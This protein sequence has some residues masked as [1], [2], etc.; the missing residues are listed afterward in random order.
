MPTPAEQSTWEDRRIQRLEDD[1]A[2]LSSKI[3]GVTAA[4]GAGLSSIGAQIAAL[5]ISMPDHYMPRREYDVTIKLL[6]GRL[7][8]V[9]ETQSKALWLVLGTLLT[10][11]I[12]V[13]LLAFRGLTG[14]I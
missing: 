5:Q 14:H 4:L 11:L 12:N 6:D 7:K 9:E 10:T 13:A 1:F 8:A 3:D 2:K